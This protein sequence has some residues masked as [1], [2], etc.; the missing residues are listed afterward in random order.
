MGK[1]TKEEKEKK[2]ILKSLILKNATENKCNRKF[3]PI[4]GCSVYVK[5]AIKLLKCIAFEN[6]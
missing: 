6:K 3:E 1:K 4:H 2:L 5:V